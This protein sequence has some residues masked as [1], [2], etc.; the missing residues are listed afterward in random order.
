M[1]AGRGSDDTV[2]NIKILQPR[3]RQLLGQRIL[4]VQQGDPLTSK[5]FDKLGPPPCAGEGASRQTYP[6]DCGRRRGPPQ[7]SGYAS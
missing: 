4:D 2:F 6:S 7:T 5:D 1:V 3:E